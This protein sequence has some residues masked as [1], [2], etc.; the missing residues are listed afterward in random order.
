MV[1]ADDGPPDS[2]PVPERGPVRGESDAAVAVRETE[3]DENVEYLAASNA[4]RYVAARRARPAARGGT[5]AGERHEADAPA[6][7][8]VFRTVPVE[9]WGETRCL[10]A[11]ARVAAA[12]AGEELGT[13]EPT[14]GVV[15]AVEGAERVA[16]LSV[17]TVLDGDGALVHDPGVAFDAL[18]AA[19]PASVDATYV[20]DGREVHRDVPVYARHEV[21]R[22][23]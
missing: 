18:V 22:E 14:G 20:L 11:A 23:G 16:C 6:R 5:D 13:D 2:P 8:P 7:E 1:P 17:T 4:V 19:T 10:A 15:A 21:I 3:D 9:R 12:H